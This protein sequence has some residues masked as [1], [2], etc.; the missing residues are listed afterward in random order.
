MFASQL[1]GNWRSLFERRNRPAW[2]ILVFGLLLTLLVWLMQRAQDAEH[3]KHQFARHVQS[4]VD[5][6]RERNQQQEQI[7]LGAAGLFAFSESMQREDWHTYIE[8]LNLGKNYPGIQGIG[9]IAVIRP[10]ALQAHIA[11]MRAKGFP[12][13]T[14]WPAGKRELYTSI[15]YMEP[16]TGSNLAAFGYDM[17][18]E[19][20]RA[21]AMRRAGETGNTAISGEVW[22]IHENQKKE[23][24][25]FLMYV[26]VYRKNQPL[27]TAAERWAALQGFVFSRFRMKDQ[28]QG[29]LGVSQ[30]KVDIAI[31]D[32]SI[33]SDNTLMYRSDA[34]DIEKSRLPKFSTTRTI[35]VFGH[36]WTIQMHSL[37]QF[38]AESLPVLEWVLLL[39]GGSTSVLLF[40]LVWLLG[41]RR[42][43][44][45]VLASNSARLQSILDTVL[46]GIITIEELGIVESFN[47][48]AERIFGYAAAEVI[49]QNVKLLMPDSYRSQH[50]SYLEH[51]RATGE[52]HIIGQS[53]EVVGRHKDGSLFPMDMS[54]NAMSLGDKRRFTGIVRDISARK[55]T[56][57]KIARSIKE[58]GD[59]K[60]AL[61]EHAIVAT[62]DSR[63][64]ITYVNDKFCAIS[65]YTREELIGQNHRLVNSR[66]HP[67]TFFNELWQTIRSGRVWKGEIKNRAKDD[68]IYWVNTTIVPFLDEHGKP[69]QYIAI[70]TD[71]TARLQAEE[72]LVVAREAADRANLAKDS[73]LATMSHEI[74]TPLGGL[75]GM[76]ELLGYTPLNN[77]QRETV[78]AAIDSGQSLLRIVN[79]ILDWSKIEAGKLELA[80][81]SIS[82]TQL[83]TSV[84]NTYARVASA[85]SLILEHYIDPRLNPAHLIDPLRL[86]QVLNNFLSN[87]LKFTPKGQ[88]K[89]RADLIGKLEHAEQVRFS[90]MDNGIGIAKDVQEH[91]FMNYSQGSADTARMY[92]GTGLGLSICRRLAKLMDGQL[93]LESTPGVGSTF[94][95]T[96]TLPISTRA[97][98]PLLIDREMMHIAHMQLAIFNGAK[99]DA[100]LVLVVDDHPINRRLMAIQLGLL[101]L[102]AETAETGDVALA[103]WRGDRFDLIITDCH[104]PQMD[105]YDLTRAIRKEETED[106]RPRTPVIAWTA[107]ALPGEKARCLAAGMDELLVKPVDMD[108]LRATLSRCL[109]ISDANSTAPVENEVSRCT[110]AVPIDY[111]V[112][113]DLSDDAVEKIEILQDFMVQTR[114]DLAE[115]AEALK[116]QDVPA[117][118]HIVHRMKGASRMVGACELAMACRAIENAARQGNLESLGGATAAMERLEAHLAGADTQIKDT[119]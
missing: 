15:I 50:D 21:N 80:P 60:A 8:Q 54:V 90:V 115:L 105:G 5:S 66:Y 96:L 78:Q 106:A 12:D 44:A 29:I 112:L 87:A 101:G 68:S 34:P 16:F 18:F 23:Q 69:V 83:V 97:V 17:F 117:T 76:L 41:E 107:N 108:R 116:K 47:P 113:A 114:L 67:Q 85:N 62:T 53:M 35:E 91:L 100:P 20:I 45:L 79:D 86:S 22:A 75:M 93:D 71:I 61:D 19:A 40:V 77:D 42:A 102:R 64:T 1:L 6:I 52:S 88:I 81:Q 111:K 65:K 48:A 119:K 10:A 3:A 73:F 38:E 11:A 25:G 43:R 33:K 28:M 27:N 94:S 4:A 49:G 104:M 103:R 46:D 74:R 37:P 95:I 26:P 57:V 82:I 109:I 72:E 39:L 2:W 110:H 89:V 24:A 58:L 30:S 36:P 14:V 32:G 55:E 70:R 98:E 13:Y 99:A 7:L 59:F 31:Y 118:V 63:G 9:Y 51:F 84:V 56:D 92:G